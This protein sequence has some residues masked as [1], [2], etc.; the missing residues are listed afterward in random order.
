MSSKPI[1]PC[2]SVLQEL[3]KALKQIDEHAKI[4]HYSLTFERAQDV[5][6]A[7]LN[8]S[9]SD[10]ESIPKHITIICK[11]PPQCKLRK[12]KPYTKVHFA[13]YASLYDIL[14]DLKEKLS[15]NNFSIYKQLLQHWDFSLTDWIV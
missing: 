1:D 2:S 8:V 4:V 13:F 7:P 9:I 14:D 11:F 3:E 15:H 6:V 5:Y 10:A 12:G